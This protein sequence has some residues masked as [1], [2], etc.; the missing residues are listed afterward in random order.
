MGFV[1]SAPVPSPVAPCKTVTKGGDEGYKPFILQGSVSL[2]GEN[3]DQVPIKILRDT[4][5]NQSLM[6]H[7]ILPFS[8]S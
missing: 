5:A 6:L 3:V 7:S 1:Q 2:M 4:G 8:V